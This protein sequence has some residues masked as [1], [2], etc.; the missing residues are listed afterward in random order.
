MVFFLPL[1]ARVLITNARDAATF[2]AHRNHCVRIS[3]VCSNVVA[4]GRAVT[5]ATRS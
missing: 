4:R 5:R 3:A 2:V 1:A